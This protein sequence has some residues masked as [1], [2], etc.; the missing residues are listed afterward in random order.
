[1][2]IVVPDYVEAF[3]G[4]RVWRL[5]GGSGE[6]RLLS[7]LHETV[8]PPHRELLAECLG[9]HMLGRLWRRPRHEAPSEACACGIYATSL[10]RLRS[11]LQERSD[12]RI[13]SVFGRVRLW[14]TVVECEQGWRA[15]RA[16]PAEILVPALPHSSPAHASGE[17]IADGLSC[18]GAPVVVL[19]HTAAEAVEVVAQ[20]RGH[21][22]RIGFVQ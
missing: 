15:S 16:Y 10:D 4:W 1:M 21:G 19:P 2:T 17:E 7:V 5:D 12:R 22:G 8:W 20:E 11:Y 13:G 9:R 18:Y 3:E 14:G 6:L